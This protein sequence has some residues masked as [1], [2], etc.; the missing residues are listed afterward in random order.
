MDITIG[1]IGSILT[2]IAGLIT[3]CGV[4]YG[5]GSKLATKAVKDVLKDTNSKLDQLDKKIDANTLENCKNYIVKYLARF[6]RNEEP[7]IEETKRFWENYDIYTS[8]GGNSYIHEKVE[9]LKKEGK[10]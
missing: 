3:A 10:L 4:I 6:D 5:F 2:F 1:Q 8:M 7:T 9:H